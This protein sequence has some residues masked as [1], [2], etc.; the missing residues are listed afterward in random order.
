MKIGE[1]SDKKESLKTVE[2]EKKG[3]KFK[4]WGIAVIILII[5]V[6]AF[7]FL[8]PGEKLIKKEEKPVPGILGGRGLEVEKDVWLGKSEERMKVLEERSKEIEQMLNSLKEKMGKEKELPEVERY[9][10]PPP[11]PP[12]IPGKAEKET[13]SVQKKEEIKHEEAAPE[14]GIESIK[15]KKTAVKATVE[16]KVKK[17]SFLPAGSFVRGT[18]L[19]GLDAPA[20][21]QSQQRPL[22]V[23][24][25]LDS[26]SI[27]PNFSTFNV[28]ECFMVGS[29]FGSSS[30]ERAFIRSETLS[31]VTPGGKVINTAI[32]GQVVGEDGK[33][34]VRGR[35]VSKQG[36]LL[37]QSLMAGFADG[38][39]RAFGRAE[40]TVITTPLG[41]TQ[42]ILTGSPLK[43]GLFSGISRSMEELSR[44]YLDMARQTFPVIEIDAGRKIEI[45]ITEGKEMEDVDV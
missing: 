26:E 38:L 20:G 11:P 42:E 29:S 10:V 32:K 33:I 21:P 1:E 15:P 17:I 28:K 31:C 12:L 41:G 7:Q 45:F 37:A 27:G 8:R 9:P 6:L 13:P 22:P 34:G 16:K 23:L 30:E 3:R 25:R 40:S 19:T 18:L 36:A 44:F 14:E 2:D 43:A 4:T 35:L 24:I 39:A 5:L